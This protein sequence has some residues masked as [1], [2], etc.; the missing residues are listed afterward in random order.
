MEKRKPTYDLA[1]IKAAI[2]AAETLSITSSALRDAVGLGLDRGGHRK[3]H[4]D[5]R[6][7]HVLQVDDDARRSLSV[8][9]RVPCARREWP[10]TV[11]EVSS[12]RRDRV[13]GDVVQGEVT[14]ATKVGT[15]PKTTS[16]PET[17]ETLTR[18]VR[19]FKVTYKGKT[20]TVDLPG[21]YPKGDGD[22]VHVGNDMSVVDRALRML[23]EKVDGIPAPETIRKVRTK[24]RLSQRR[25][26][27]LFRVGP[28][29]FDKYERG[30]IEPSGPTVQL[31]T[32]LN[33][34]PELV[35]ELEGA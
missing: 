22:G 35:K 19:P 4:P 2:G 27:A 32:I 24:L 21:Y 10:D 26:G 5:H 29:A 28:N 31:I 17:G 20:I 18:G 34:H 30:L 8:A 14:M 12:K 15:L 11:R 16:S 3:R 23:K 6:A 1:A 33:R 25:A 13:H 7:A 9:G